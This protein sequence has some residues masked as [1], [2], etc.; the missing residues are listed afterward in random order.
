MP[1]TQG[2]LGGFT[3]GS[4]GFREKLIQSFTIFVPCLKLIGLG[5]K[6]VIAELFKLRLQLIYSVY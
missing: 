5:T 3:D 2:S 4:K 1:Q 6:L